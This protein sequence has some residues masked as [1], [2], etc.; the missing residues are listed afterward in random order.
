VP[1]TPPDWQSQPQLPRG[2]RFLRA[3]DAS[4]EPDAAELRAFG[5]AVHALWPLLCRQ[6]CLC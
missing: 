5:L 4:G 1:C 3:L 2:H 6:V